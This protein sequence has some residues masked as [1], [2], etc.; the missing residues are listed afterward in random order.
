MQFKGGR[1]CQ[2]LLAVER[3]DQ[4]SVPPCF[5]EPSSC[6]GVMTGKQASYEE[7]IKKIARIVCFSSGVL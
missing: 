3:L 7:F 6:C 2:T 1:T 4:L 5:V